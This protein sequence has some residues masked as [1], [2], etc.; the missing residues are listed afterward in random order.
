MSVAMEP[1]PATELRK[2]ALGLGFIV[3][4]VIS[5]AGPLVAIA[6]G[7]PIGI[8]LGNGAGTPAL[9]VAT[10]AILLLFAAG[11]TAMARH[12]TNAGGFYAFTARGLGGTA[13]GA[14]A[15][16]ALLGYNTMTEPLSDELIRRISPIHGAYSDIR[17]V[18]NYYRVTNENRLLFGS[19]TSLVEHIPHDLKEWNRR[20]MVEVFPYLSDVKIDL[21]WG[22]PMASTL[23]LFPQIGPLADRPN[24][25]FV[26]GYSGFGVTPS[27]IICKILAEGILGGSDR[28][29]LVSSIPRATIKG[30]DRYRNLLVTLGKVMHQSTGYW[31]G[32][33]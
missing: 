21:A 26:Q 31:H 11:Y 12:V 29:R 15:L 4:F 27:Q 8:M 22:G 33:R 18:I 28:Y 14:A 23:N 20:L 13:G 19:S 10:V 16:I 5:A 3:F 2:G 9:L 17:P 6:G 32:R 25:F 1:T 24:A 7:L 30:K